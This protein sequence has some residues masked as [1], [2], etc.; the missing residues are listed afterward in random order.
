MTAKIHQK[1]GFTLLETMIAIAVLLIGVVGPIS[2]IGDSLSKIYYAKDQIIAVNLAQEGIEVVRQ[3]RDTNFL[4]TATWNEG[5]A[6]GDCPGANGCMVNIEN[7]G[8]SIIKCGGTC[9]FKVY[10]DSVD[11]LYHQAIPTPPAGP[12]ITITNFTRKVETAGVGVEVKITSTV[13]W[14]TGGKTGTVVV[15][16][17][18]FKWAQ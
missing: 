4:A 17:N 11:G 9:D 14:T 6:S 1:S 8:I 12:A 7:S 16:E 3:V 2:I 13:T 5:F 15:S 18:L 10:L